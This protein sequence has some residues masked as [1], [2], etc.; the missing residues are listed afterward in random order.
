MN[1]GMARV[2]IRVVLLWVAGVLAVLAMAVAVTF[3]V[4]A[5]KY[6]TAPFRGEVDARERTV[7]SGA[8]RLATYE[9]FFSLCESVQNSEAQISSLELELETEPP[10][11]RVT[12]INSSLSAIRST[13]AA[14]IN[15]YNSKAGQEH[16]QAFQDNNL[17]ERLDINNE[18]TQCAS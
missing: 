9:E 6:L 1:R 4:G 18:G 14:S 10:Q 7:A 11:A 15:E 17:P 16:R 12:V 8:F 3:A 2:G 13:R 5:G